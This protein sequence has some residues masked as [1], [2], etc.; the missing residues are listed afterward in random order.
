MKRI[1]IINACEPPKKKIEKKRKKKK[2]IG[3]DRNRIQN[4]ISIDSLVINN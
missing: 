2:K 3:R 1:N 4:Q